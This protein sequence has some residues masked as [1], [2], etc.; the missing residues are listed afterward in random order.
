MA[1]VIKDII[2]PLSKATKKENVKQIEYRAEENELEIWV[3]MADDKDSES[4]IRQIINIKHYL[5][6]KH[7]NLSI[8]LHIIKSEK[9]HQNN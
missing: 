8:S 7:Q 2:M 1:N 4:A 6:K 3:Y 5:V 9:S